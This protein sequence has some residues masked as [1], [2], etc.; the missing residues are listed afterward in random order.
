M[1]PNAKVI[2]RTVGTTSLLLA[3]AMLV[4]GE[5]V[6]KDRLSTIAFLFYWLACFLL[7]LLAVAAALL[8]ARAVRSEN[9]RQQRE[10]LEN[11]LGKIR[12]RDPSRD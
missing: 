5:T 7:T 6:L 3:A 10:L 2:R 9:R 4:A 12:P 8:D 1:S 11:T